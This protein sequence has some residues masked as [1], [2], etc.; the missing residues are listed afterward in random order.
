MK[1]LAREFNRM[2]PHERITIATI[3]LKAKLHAGYVV[4]MIDES[5]FANFTDV[6]FGF[7]ILEA[8]LDCGLSEDSPGEY[9]LVMAYH[10]KQ[11]KF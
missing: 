4:R 11:V 8:G 7:E 10:P 6:F 1:G 2:G 5:L 9:Q 3:R